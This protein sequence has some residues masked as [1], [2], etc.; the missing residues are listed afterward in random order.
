MDAVWGMVLMVSLLWL[1]CMG[2]SL[3]SL[4]GRGGASMGERGGFAGGATGFGR[5][6]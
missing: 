6:A 3:G 2:Y 5:A 1:A 4:V